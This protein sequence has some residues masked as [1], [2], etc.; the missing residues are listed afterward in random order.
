MIK[1]K[2]YTSIS[3][4]HMYNPGICVSF[5]SHGHTCSW[6]L[7]RNTFITGL[8]NVLEL[9]NSST[10]TWQSS[11]LLHFTSIIGIIF[12]NFPIFWSLTFVNSYQSWNSSKVECSKSYC[13]GSI[14]IYQYWIGLLNDYNPFLKVSSARKPLWI[15]EITWKL[16]K[17]FILSR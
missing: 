5:N 14:F 8:C 7:P 15:P 1:K 2:P 9:R 17:M 11:L 16:Q 12:L 10:N 6:K 13:R 3:V 4:I